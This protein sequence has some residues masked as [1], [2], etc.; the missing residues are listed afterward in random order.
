MG[1]EKSE[2]GKTSPAN[3]T[4]ASEPKVK[5]VE[6]P[7]PKTNP[8]KKVDPTVN[9]VITIKPK[10]V[11]NDD[12][13][14]S[15][16]E[17]AKIIGDK[18]SNVESKF[19]QTVKSNSIALDPQQTVEKDIKQLSNQSETEVFSKTEK[20]STVAMASSKKI[21][22]EETSI[23]TSTSTAWQ[24]TAETMSKLVPLKAE[25]VIF[26]DFDANCYKWGLI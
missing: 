12:T 7:I 10:T 4:D 20:S 23:S 5:Y 1:K 15:N 9:D 17:T 6:A 16:E 11:E 14:S 19:I 3:V 26:I 2:S 25:K 24:T 8:W 18:D 22:L 21:I 13:N